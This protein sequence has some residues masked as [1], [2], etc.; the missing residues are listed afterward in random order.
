MDRR[1]FIS[2][3]S[4]GLRDT[5][6]QGAN[7]DNSPPDWCLGR[8]GTAKSCRARSIIQIFA[9]LGWVEGRI[10]SSGGNTQWQ[11]GTFPAHGEELVPQVEIIATRDTRH[12]SAKN[13][14]HDTHSRIRSA[15]PRHS[16][17]VASMAR[18]GGNIT[19]Y[20]VVG[21]EL[22]L[23]RLGV[24]HELLPTARRVGWLENS[25]NPYYRSVRKELENE[26]QT[27]GIEPIFVEVAKVSELESAVAE[28]ARERGQ[29]LIVPSDGLFHD[30]RTQIMRDAMSHML[31]TVV[32]RKSMLGAG[33]LVSYGD[34]VEELN[35]RFA[36]FID[37][38]LRGAK[39]AD[40]PIEQPTNSN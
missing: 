29:A 17:L 6:P 20:S 15:E 34:T 8:R 10:F 40:L 38:I 21:P 36:A 19:G 31:P 16:D 23:K 2:A 24:L 1:I 26:C 7:C 12:A 13:R 11:G 22:D 4:C 14:Q 25:T 39:P 3:V 32:E 30:N 9:E 27:L 28:V 37:R 18:P 35:N 5:S 33:A